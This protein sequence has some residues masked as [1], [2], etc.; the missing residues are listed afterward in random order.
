MTIINQELVHYMKLDPYAR[1]KIDIE[2]LDKYL[3]S[4]FRVI[5][6]WCISKPFIHHLKKGKRKIN[7]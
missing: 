7:S 2:K 6:Y 1:S 4:I 5:F 3:G